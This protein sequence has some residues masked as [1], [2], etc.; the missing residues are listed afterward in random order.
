MLTKEFNKNKVLK[1]MEYSNEVLKIYFNKGQ[2]R[3][4]NS[5]PPPIAYTLFYKTNATDTL[6]F[7]STQ[8]KKKFEVIEVINK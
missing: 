4:Y 8:I 2:V 3:V 5:V 1:A 7:Y 6:H